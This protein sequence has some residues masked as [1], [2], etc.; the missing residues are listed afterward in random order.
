MEICV[1]MLSHV[2]LCVTPRAI[3][4]QT[5]LSVGFSR[6]EYWS[7]LP[8]PPPGDL[9]S[10]GIEPVSPELQVDSLPAEPP[11]SPVEMQMDTDTERWRSINADGETEEERERER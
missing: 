8:C 2:R 1:C 10:P 11:G 6:Q 3:A 7:G 5:P 9:L 4:S